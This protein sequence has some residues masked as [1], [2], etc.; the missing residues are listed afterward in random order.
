MVPTFLPGE[1]LAMSAQAADRL[2]KLDSGDA[3]LV[4]L[5]L[6]RHGSAKGLKWTDT[7][8]QAA[9]DQLRK[10]GMAPA[11]LPAPEPVV[12]EAP[13]PD[14]STQDIAQALEDQSSTFPALAGEVERRPFLSQIRKEGFAWARRG[15]DT[16]ER[17]EDHIAR[18]TRLHSREAEVL[19]LLDISPRPLVQREKDYI[20]VWDEMGFDDESIR[21]AYERTV[22]KKQSMDWGYMNGILR[23]WHEK[24]LHTAAAVRTG[25]RD[26]RPVQAGAGNKRPPSAGQD[27]RARED[28]ERMRRLMEQMKQEES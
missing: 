3:A 5:C 17:A 11:E 20:A 15:V 18:L 26:P 4:Y 6:L 10:Q 14:Y 1:V 13:P 12:E 27:Q 19:R 9:L 8:L 24:G 7:R 16:M 22:L 23:R 25:D 2:L 21:M 28:M